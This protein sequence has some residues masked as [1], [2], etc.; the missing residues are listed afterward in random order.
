MTKSEVMD[1]DRTKR[2]RGNEVLA[3]LSSDLRISLIRC[4]NGILL[5]S[6]MSFQSSTHCVLKGFHANAAKSMR[7]AP[8]IGTTVSDTSAHSTGPA[9]TIPTKVNVR[10]M[11]LDKVLAAKPS[12]NVVLDS[13]GFLGSSEASGEGTK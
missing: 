8:A 5:Y 6:R 11:M 2:R 4:L 13:M 9:T 7:K 12:Q 10:I 3:P 1:V